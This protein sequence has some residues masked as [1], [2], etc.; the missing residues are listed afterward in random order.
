[1]S[2]LTLR[3]LA[4]AYSD[5]IVDRK[6]YIRE[7]RQ[8]IDDI[9]SGEAE[10]I[11]YEPSP[12]PAIPDTERTFSDGAAT[13]E[14]VLIN[15][16]AL[17]SPPTS[18]NRAL[19]IMAILVLTA[20]VVIG[21]FKLAPK[22]ESF[23]PA[24]IDPNPSVTPINRASSAEELLGNFLDE[25]QWQNERIDGF[26][27][28]WRRLPSDVKLA[29]VDSPSMHRAVEVIYQ[30]FLEEK[31]LLELGDRAEVLNAQRQMLKLAAELSPD[32]RRVA[33]LEDEWRKIQTEVPTQP[34]VPLQ[35][36]AERSTATSSEP[37]A[38]PPLPAAGNS[39][40]VD[41]M[42]TVAG[43]S[44]EISRQFRPSPTRF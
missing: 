33:Q 17:L 40:N 6:Q 23:V 32:N 7:R 11:P 20:V 15:T 37:V 35:P 12:P 38:T 2:K 26:L 34:H 19:I 28:E 25:N 14:P 43:E 3:G 22:P 29:L 9:I 30:N 13:L 8:L 1:M 27:E 44:N 16:E 41:P 42:V 36:V 5:N 31:A 24:R 4:K 39:S 18:S 21:W 10:L